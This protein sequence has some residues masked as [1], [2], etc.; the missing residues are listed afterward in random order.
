MCR[1]FSG[2]KDKAQSPILLPRVVSAPGLSPPHLL[3]A[4]SAR[5][6]C[7]LGGGFFNKKEFKGDSSTQTEQHLTHEMPWCCKAIPA[8][9]V[10]GL[11]DH[12]LASGKFHQ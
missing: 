9:T 1:L 7:H 2:G 10:R 5:E 4:V 8:G 11:S 3:R 6:G 12:T